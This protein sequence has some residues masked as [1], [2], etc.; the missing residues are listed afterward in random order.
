[1]DLAYGQHTFD[2]R[3]LDSAAQADP[4]P[5]SRTFE[6]VAARA[7]IKKVGI[8]GPGKAKR[9]K[10]TTYRIKVTN[11]GNADAT[12]VKLQAKGKGV[13]A[14]KNVGNIPAGVSKTVK[15]K[16]KFKKPGK[17]KT[18]FKVTSANAGGK[19][20]KKTIRVKK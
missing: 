18:T 15:A 9:G 17:V 3:A 12:G 14:N 6:V 5:A 10:K 1:M 4:T 16:L 20:V 8:I 7:R 2:V 19:T 13:K 11:S